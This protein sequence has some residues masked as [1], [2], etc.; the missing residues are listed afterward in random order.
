MVLFQDFKKSLSIIRDN[1]TQH[2]APCRTPLILVG[3]YSLPWQPDKQTDVQKDE[4]SDIMGIPT[5]H[6]DR[7]THRQTERQNRQTQKDKQTDRQT[8]STCVLCKT[9]R[10]EIRR[11]KKVSDK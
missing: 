11:T 3:L 10:V 5:V 8:G 9:D 4:C 1:Y 6:T 2:L 7:Q